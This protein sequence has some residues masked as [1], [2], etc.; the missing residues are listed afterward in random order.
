MHHLVIVEN[1]GGVPV[2]C[3]LAEDEDDE[4]LLTKADLLSWDD[5]LNMEE[6]EY[7]RERDEKEKE[8]QQQQQQ[9]SQQESDNEASE[10]EDDEDEPD[11]VMYAGMFRTAMDWLQDAGEFL[12]EPSFDYIIQAENEAIEEEEEAA[13]DAEADVVSEGDNEND[14][15]DNSEDDSSKDG[16]DGDDSQESDS[17]NSDSD[18]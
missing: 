13:V 11:V 2:C 18:D 6:E 12:K 5:K 8:K 4:K 3:P 9:L 1:V 15:D 14:R 10:N 17:D 16:E 7:E